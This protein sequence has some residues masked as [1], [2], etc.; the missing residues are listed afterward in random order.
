[1]EENCRKSCGLC[2]KRKSE[3]CSEHHRKKPSTQRS[4]AVQAKASRRA[5]S[6]SRRHHPTKAH[7]SNSHH[8]QRTSSVSARKQA[9]SCTVTECFNEDKCCD[10]WKRQGRCTTDVEWMNCNCKV[11]CKV[12]QPTYDFGSCTDYHGSCPA[13][14][15]TGE[16]KT[17]PWMMENCRTS[18]QA[19]RKFTKRVLRK[20]CHIG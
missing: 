19:C 4:E 13:W 1:M 16:C 9:A 10:E 15:Q 6:D 2:K 5:K 14:G 3:Q 17:N 18:C 20:Q 7:L 8:T 11:S 12:C